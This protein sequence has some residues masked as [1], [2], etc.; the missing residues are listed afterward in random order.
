M[1]LALGGLLTVIAGVQLHTHFISF[2][3]G[4]RGRKRESWDYGCHDITSTLD[5]TPRLPLHILHLH[6]PYTG[7]NGADLYPRYDHGVQHLL[8]YLIFIKSL[9]FFS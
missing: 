2:F 9:P 3:A 6:N 5:R 4:M 7:G 1:E 8:V